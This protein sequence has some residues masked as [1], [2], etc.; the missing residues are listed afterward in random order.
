MKAS[1]KV[2]I[3]IAGLVLLSFL[4][5][6]VVCGS[7][8]KK[9]NDQYIISAAELPEALAF[10]GDSVPLQKFDVRESLDREIH[11][12]IYFQSQTILILKR[13]NRFLP[14]IERILKEEGV[15]ADFKYLAVAESGLTNVVSPAKAAGFWQF[16][17]STGQKYNLKITDEVDERYHLEKATRAACQYLKE[18]YGMFGNW[19]LAAAAYNVGENR[20]KDILAN[21]KVSSYYDLWLN[22]ETARYIFRILAL[23]LIIENPVAYGFSIPEKDLYQPL[24]YIELSVDSTVTDLARFAL[25]QKSNLKMLVYFNPWIRSNSLTCKTNE[26]YTIRIPAPGFRES[27]ESSNY[28]SYLQQNCDTTSKHKTTSF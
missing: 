13:A 5:Y 20:L 1:Y 4:G 21:Q 6:S 8:T 23:K 17:K 7:S 22:E 15:P 25:A 9:V 3:I 14:E 19:T 16:L 26:K 24:Q 18:L 28:Q 10:A 11:I 27:V 12:N 2:S